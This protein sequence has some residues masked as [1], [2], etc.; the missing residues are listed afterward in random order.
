MV[1]WKS[2]CMV[3]GIIII[4]AGTD[5]DG[6]VW[7]A[8]YWWPFKVWVLIQVKD[9]NT[10]PTKAKWL[11]C[12]GGNNADA[13]AGDGRWLYFPLKLFHFAERNRKEERK[14][15][16]SCPYARMLMLKA[17]ASCWTCLWKN[18]TRRN[19]ARHILEN[20]LDGWDVALGC[21]RP[22]SRSYYE[23]GGLQW[24]L[25]HLASGS[26][27]PVLF[28]E[29][30]GEPG[31]KSQICTSHWGRGCSLYSTSCP[32]EGVLGK[33]KTDG[34]LF[35]ERCCWLWKGTAFMTVKL[36]WSKKLSPDFVLRFTARL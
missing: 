7:V 20:Q 13:W 17:G 36:W 6:I 29:L 15:W 28:H 16:I 5:E 25:G 2:G 34:I 18:F 1:L 26:V 14:V 4:I 22:R 3:L 9:F 27:A 21:G 19:Q 23:L 24:L 32:L 8:L 30:P 35:S 10:H 12:P 33:T 31:Y 11:Y